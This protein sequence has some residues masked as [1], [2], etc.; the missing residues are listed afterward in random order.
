MY[1]PPVFT[2]GYDSLFGNKTDEEALKNT[3]KISERLDLPALVCYTKP[4]IWRFASFGR[5]SV[6]VKP[7]L[8]GL[9]AKSP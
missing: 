5:A 6:S 9:A 1:K 7:F 8:A 3:E 2:G 4:T